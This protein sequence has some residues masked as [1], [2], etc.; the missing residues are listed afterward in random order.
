VS[1]AALLARHTTTA[2]ETY[3]PLEDTAG[4]ARVGLWP[5]VCGPLTVSLQNAGNS[6]NAIVHIYYRV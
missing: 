2:L 3:L 6:K 4:T 5:V 1:I